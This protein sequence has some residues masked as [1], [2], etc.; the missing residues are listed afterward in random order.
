MVSKEEKT[1]AAKLK[2]AAGL[3]AVVVESKE[4][5]AAAARRAGRRRVAQAGLEASEAMNRRNAGRAGL[6]LAL[7]SQLNQT[8]PV[9][10]AHRIAYST[11]PA[12]N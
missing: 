4:A 6:P 7:P 3:K 1:K 8:A 10:A 2:A 12:S 9:V 11:T 5:V